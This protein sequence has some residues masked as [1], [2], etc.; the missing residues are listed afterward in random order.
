MVEPM[1]EYLNPSEERKQ[2][3]VS[4]LKSAIRSSEIS[5][6]L[7]DNQPPPLATKQDRLQ[8]ETRATRKS[9]FFCPGCFFMNQALWSGTNIRIQEGVWCVMKNNPQQLEKRIWD[10]YIFWLKI[11]QVKKQRSLLWSLEE[12]Y[13]HYVHHDTSDEGAVAREIFEL[14]LKQ[15]T[16]RK[17][18]K[19]R[20]NERPGV[21]EMGYLA[22]DLKIGEHI[23]KMKNE[24][25]TKKLKQ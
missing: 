19:K 23:Q 24:R 14:K 10:S 17:C 2:L 1:Q 20:A 15:A 3:M 16:L 9:P 21:A 6:I 25:P 4:E 7:P 11:A 22:V 13:D 18:W 5:E 12:F 8:L